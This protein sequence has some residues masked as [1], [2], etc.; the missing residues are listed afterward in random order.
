MKNLKMYID[1][2]YNI[3]KYIYIIYWRKK[4]TVHTLGVYN[5]VTHFLITLIFHTDGQVSDSNQQ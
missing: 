3:F 4:E 1:T 2:H 5:S